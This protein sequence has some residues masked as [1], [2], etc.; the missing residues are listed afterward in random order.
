MAAQ[1][2]VKFFKKA[3]KVDRAIEITDNEAYIPAVK[4]NPEIRVKLPNR[5]LRTTEERQGILEERIDKLSAIE[6]EIEV[7]SKQ[8]LAL[9]KSYNQG[10]S[11]ASEVVAQNLKVRSLMEKRS[12]I[13]RPEKWIEDLP[14]LTMKDVFESKRDIR[15]LGKGVLVHQIKRRVEPIS[16]LYIDLEAA[17]VAAEPAVEAPSLEPSVTQAPKTP[18]EIAQGVI[19]G[20]RTL[21]KKNP[22]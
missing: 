14:G 9:V 10:A 16:S 22:V 6:E 5:R 19:I 4:D 13:D 2:D 8:L 17:A 18:A 11:G 3:K 20:R 15:K 12:A 21:S 1:L 7:E